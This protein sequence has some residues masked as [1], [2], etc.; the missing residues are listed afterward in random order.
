MPINQN[1]QSRRDTLLNL[2]RSPLNR[3]SIHP[4]TYTNCA[5]L[6]NKNYKLC[7]AGTTPLL[8]QSPAISISTGSKPHETVQIPQLP[9]GNRNARMKIEG[10]CREQMRERLR[11]C[12]LSW[13]NRNK[14]CSSAKQEPQSLQGWHRTT[15][16]SMIACE[17]PLKSLRTFKKHCKLFSSPNW[18]CTTSKC[19][20][21]DR[22]IAQRSNF[23]E[24][25][26][27]GRF[28]REVR[29]ERGEKRGQLLR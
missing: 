1:S 6:Q 23:G 25:G 3:D 10:L 12:S 13:T 11:T 24:R 26:S 5:Y 22:K 7:K 20:R 19:T 18:K 8:P 2:L 4:R 27:C 9:V 21:D 14:V 16:A 15:P 29:G 17:S 28:S